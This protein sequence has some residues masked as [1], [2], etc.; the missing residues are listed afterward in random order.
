MED[1]SDQD[2]GLPHGKGRCRG[3]KTGEKKERSPEWWGRE[4]TEWQ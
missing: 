2:E 1:K 4:L 3:F